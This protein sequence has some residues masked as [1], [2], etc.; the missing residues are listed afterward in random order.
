MSLRL[1]RWVSIWLGMGLAL[2]GLA[3]LVACARTSSSA[4]TPTLSNTP[5]PI[6][7][8]TRD[9]VL[10]SPSPTIDTY[11]ATVGA[12]MATLPT[13]T[14]IVGMF[15]EKAEQLQRDDLYH[16]ALHALHEQGIFTPVPIVTL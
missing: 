7:T 2:L 1:S 6:S 15:R 12:M 8:G 13:T 9:M 11:R 3:G 4:T 10:V 14:P 5:G 16:R